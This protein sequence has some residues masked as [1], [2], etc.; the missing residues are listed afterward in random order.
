MIRVQYSLKCPRCAHEYYASLFVKYE[1]EHCPLCGLM[2]LFDDFCP[3]SALN[4]DEKPP[5]DQDTA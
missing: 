3:E 5:D 2:A 4:L 1:I